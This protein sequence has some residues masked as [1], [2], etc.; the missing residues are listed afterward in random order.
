MS[1]PEAIEFQPA[2]AIKAIKAIEA[3]AS[4]PKRLDR[5]EL[6]ARQHESG[7]SR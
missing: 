5:G 2:E 7:R 6:K 1:V 3:V 4:E